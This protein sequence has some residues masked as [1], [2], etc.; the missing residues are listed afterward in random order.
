MRYCLNNCLVGARDSTTQSK[1]LIIFSCDLNELSWKQGPLGLNWHLAL[2]FPHY[3]QVFVYNSFNIFCLV[4]SM[5][6]RYSS[7][8]HVIVLLI[9]IFFRT[10]HFHI[11]KGD[12]R[13]DRRSYFIVIAHPVENSDNTPKIKPAQDYIH[14][15]KGNCMEWYYVMQV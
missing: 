11:W 10:G 15:G 6:S 13:I 2:Q 1:M 9:P 3:L 5:S 12:F 14:Q 4:H 8:V 7:R